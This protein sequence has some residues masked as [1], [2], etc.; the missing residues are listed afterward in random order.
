MMKETWPKTQKH[1]PGSDTSLLA[2]TRPNRTILHTKRAII[3]A[4]RIVI[5]RVRVWRDEGRGRPPYGLLD[6]SRVSV[7]ESKSQKRPKML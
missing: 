3:N 5:A 4:K 1:E 2:R 6:G 7:G